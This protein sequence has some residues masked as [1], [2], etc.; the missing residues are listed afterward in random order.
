MC[1]NRTRLREVGSGFTLGQDSDLLVRMGGKHIIQAEVH[2]CH[3]CHFSGYSADFMR[4]VSPATRK[5]F[6]ED[7][8]PLLVDELAAGSPGNSEY[9]RTPLPDVQYHWAARTAEA[10]GLPPGQQGER[11]I[12][13]YWCLRLAP[14]SLLPPSVL[15]CVKRLY[16]KWA[17]QKLRQNLRVERDRNRVYLIAELCRRNGNFLLAVSYFRKF[18][19][20]EN[21]TLYL[22]QAAAKLLRLS[23]NHVCDELTMEDVLYGGAPTRGAHPPRSS[24]S[25]SAPPAIPPAASEGEADAAGGE[26]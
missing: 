15:R 11:W 22:K 24:R 10:I 12:R 14:S 7:V 4:T 1:G 21:G 9:A 3:K 5:R 6:L 25:R 17:I 19:D 16:L 2:T 18:I 8:S 26:P 20:D 13:A 23:Q